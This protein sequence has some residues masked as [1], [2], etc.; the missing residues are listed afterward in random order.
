M[1]QQTKDHNS[2]CPSSIA[3]TFAMPT[4]HLSMSIQTIYQLPQ[5][6]PQRHRQYHREKARKKVLQI[7]S[8]LAVTQKQP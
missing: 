1:Y 4:I 5:I 2:K 3:F 8:K 6:N 7:T